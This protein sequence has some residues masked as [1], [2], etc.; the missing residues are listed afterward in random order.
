MLCC[1]KRLPTYKLQEPDGELEC[2]FRW[3]CVPEE[4][5][6]GR[7][8]STRREEV[9]MCGGMVACIQGPDARQATLCW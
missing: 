9:G 2:T 1:C 8:V 7:Q 5:H 4:T 3:Y 6:T